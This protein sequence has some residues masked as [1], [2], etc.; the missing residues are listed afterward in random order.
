MA[1]Y[2]FGNNALIP[3]ERTSFSEV[4]FRERNDIQRLL[5][6]QIDVIAPDCTTDSAAPFSGLPLGR[7]ARAHGEEKPLAAHSIACHT[8]CM[9]QRI[10]AR[11]S[12]E[13]ASKL[14]QLRKTTEK[15]TTEIVRE[16]LEAYYE[17]RMQKARP[18]Q[19]LRDVVG[20]AEVPEEL[21]SDYKDILRRSLDDKF[22][23]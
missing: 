11:I 22:R 21:S 10:N 7:R 19:L 18:A 20:I 6:K 15:D 5:K 13:L 2:E 3:I 1:I 4:G 23:S 17:A 8:T 16:S 14:E 9:T 12:E